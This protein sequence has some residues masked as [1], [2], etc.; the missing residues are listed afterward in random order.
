MKINKIIMLSILFIFII[1]CASQHKVI[2]NDR[3]PTPV[4]LSPSLSPGNSFDKKKIDDFNAQTGYKFTR[5]SYG[6]ITIE[7]TNSWSN[8]KEKIDTTIQNSPN[9]SINNLELNIKYNQSLFLGTYK[10]TLE[11]NIN[12]NVVDLQRNQI[13]LMED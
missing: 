2:Q 5:Q 7:R 1:G 10:K 13:K 4:Y 9:N 3:I 8:L 6:Y 12:G 11:T